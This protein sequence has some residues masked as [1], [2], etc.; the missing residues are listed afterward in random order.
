MLADRFG[1]AVQVG[2]RDDDAE[3]RR[4]DAEA[5]ERVARATQECDGR[6]LLG[7]VGLDLGVEQLG[8]VARR[9]AVNELLEPL[10]QE[11]ERV[12]ALGDA[13]VLGEERALGAVVDVVLER[14]NA[15]APHD[16]E[17]LVEELQEVEVVLLLRCGVLEAALDRA[18]Q[19]GA[20]LAG[21]GGEDGADGRA[22]DDDELVRLDQHRQRAAGHGE[23][24]EN[25]R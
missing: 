10:H 18:E 9:A 2:H 16:A 11:V 21:R 24:A 25:G 12:M 20:R 6:L 22:T 17:E 1:A 23:A 7:V 19:P 4:D 15:L 5:G 3:H 14:Q 8:Q 13:R